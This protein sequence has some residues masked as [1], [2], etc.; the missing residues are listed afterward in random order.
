MAATIDA[1]RAASVFANLAS[2]PMRTVAAISAAAV[3]A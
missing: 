3:N 1:V 2:T